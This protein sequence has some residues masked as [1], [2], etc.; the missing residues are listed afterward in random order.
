M[1]I[2]LPERRP[3]ATAVIP[4][5]STQKKENGTVRVPVFVRLRCAALSFASGIWG[6]EGRCP[7]CVPQKESQQ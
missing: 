3:N 5:Y 2:K 7:A 4:P 1:K 6:P